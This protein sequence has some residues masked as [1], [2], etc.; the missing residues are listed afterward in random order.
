MKYGY[1]FSMFCA[2]LGLEACTQGV[3]KNVNHD[4]KIHLSVI[5]DSDY[6]LK[7]KITSGLPDSSVIDLQI[8]RQLNVRAFNDDWKEYWPVLDS[9]PNVILKNG[10]AEIKCTVCDTGWYKHN[11]FPAGT[12]SAIDSINVDANFFSIN[13]P[14]TMQHKLEEYAKTFPK[15]DSVPEMFSGAGLILSDEKKLEMMVNLTENKK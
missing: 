11:N 3:Q 1:I 5:K 12:V 15:D 13:Q 4:L 2:F 10:Q 6:S 14:A 7:I 9:F 8:R